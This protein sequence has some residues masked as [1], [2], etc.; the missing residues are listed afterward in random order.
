MILQN[1]GYRCKKE[2]E[3]Q[4]NY[5]FGNNGSKTFLKR[6]IFILIQHNSTRY[7]STSGD[8]NI[9]KVSRSEEHTSE[10]QSRE[11]L[12][13]RLLLEKKKKRDWRNMQ[14]RRERR[15]ETRGRYAER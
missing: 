6:H 12:V 4:V 13:C 1:N 15:I 2:Q 9:E 8:E 11:N 3:K 7:F 5:P 10:L 14:H